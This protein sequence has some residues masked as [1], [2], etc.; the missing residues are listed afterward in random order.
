LILL[1]LVGNLNLSVG[2][3]FVA[4][5]ETTSTALRWALL[6]FL[7][8]PHVQDKCYAEIRDVIGSRTPS[9]RDRPSLTYL[10]ATIMET[11]RFADIVPLNVP[12]GLASDVTFRGYVIPKDAMVFPCLSS[13][14]KDPDV[15]GDPENFRPERFIDPDG[16]LTK[17]EQFIPFGIGKHSI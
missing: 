11:L 3:M 15:W 2:D 13:V 7:H 14:L 16:K 9:M 8:F 1:L 6:F 4:G 12:H 10:E 17:P 5:T